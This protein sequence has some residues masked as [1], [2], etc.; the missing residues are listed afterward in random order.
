MDTPHVVSWWRFVLF[1]HFV[2]CEQCCWR[3]SCTGFCVDICFCFSWV[4]RVKLGVKSLDHMV[5]LCSTFGGS[6]R[7]FSRAAAQFY[8]PASRAW[9]FQFILSAHHSHYQTTCLLQ[10][11]FSISP[12]LFSIMMAL[13]V[14]A[15]QYLIVVLTRISPMTNDVKKPVLCFSLFC[16][17]TSFDISSRMFCV[18]CIVLAPIWLP[19]Q[20]LTAERLSSSEPVSSLLYTQSRSDWFSV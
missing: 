18:T 11:P 3:P 13:L 14:D 6:V 15:E 1:P 12:P 5:G 17:R 20:H 2:S 19:S 9:K 8:I 4:G 7:L 16:L 10:L